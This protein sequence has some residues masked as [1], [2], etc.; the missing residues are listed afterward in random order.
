[1]GGNYTAGPD[2]TNVGQNSMVSGGSGNFIANSSD[3]VSLFNS[4]DAIVV[5][6]NFFGVNLDSDSEIESNMINLQDKVK[7]YSDGHGA[8]TPRVLRVTA[9]FVVDGTYSI[10]EIDLDT[11][12]GGLP[13]FNIT[14]TWDAVAY[15]VTVTFKMVS[16]AGARAFYIDDMTSPPSSPAQTIDGN[17][18]PYTTGMLVYDSITAYSNGTNIFII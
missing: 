4:T 3:S 15:P 18:M 11:G 8:L 12:S 1:M 7:I 13:G 9:D 5:E 6:D 16:N 14:A 17:S 2:N 10:Y